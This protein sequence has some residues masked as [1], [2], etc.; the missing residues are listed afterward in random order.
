M[1]VGLTGKAAPDNMPL[2]HDSAGMRNVD[3]ARFFPFARKRNSCR[4]DF[5]GDITNPEVAYLLSAQSK[6]I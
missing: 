6:S 3:T 1:T 2:Q 5:K 4:F